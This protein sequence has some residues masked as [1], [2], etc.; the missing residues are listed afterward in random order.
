MKHAELTIAEVRALYFDDEALLLSPYKLY[1]YQFRD[2]R[3]YFYNKPVIDMPT[4]VAFTNEIAMATGVTTL[5]KHTIPYDEGLLRYYAERGYEEATAYRD[6]RSKYGSL[7]HTIA[8]ELL[9]KRKFDLD[10]LP[11]IVAAYAAKN[12]LTV[13]VAAW[14]DYLKQDTLALAQ[15][16]IDYNVKPL[17]IELSLVSPS[18]GVAGTLDLFCEMDKE[19]TG[20]FGEVYASGDRKGQP[21]ETKRTVRVLAIVDFK[22]GRNVPSTKHNAAQLRI[23]RILLDEMM[24]TVYGTHTAAQQMELYNWHPKNWETKPGY[25]LVDQK[26]CVSTEEAMHY[27]A[28]NRVYDPNPDERTTLQMQGIISLAAGTEQN[29]TVDNIKQLVQAKV[30]AGDMP[31]EQ[32]D[33]IDNYLPHILENDEQE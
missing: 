6:D 12:A 33:C 20:F 19:E 26:H 32:Y 18:L 11:G 8:A 31:L 3:Y 29:Y 27:I 25:R 24:E 4:G 17:A 22:S 13:N 15:F 16:I 14:V 10:Q 1:R 23:L 5:T 2:D 9:I 28:L 7:L 21:K 30:T